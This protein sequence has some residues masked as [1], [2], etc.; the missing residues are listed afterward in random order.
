MMIAIQENV[1][2]NTDKI[3]IVQLREVRGKVRLEV[4]VENKSFMV[5]EDKVVGEFKDLLRGTL[6]NND[7][8]MKQ[9]TS[10]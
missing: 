6:D 9:F 8:L 7:K 5:D 1:L 2:V 3:S 4:I 10:V